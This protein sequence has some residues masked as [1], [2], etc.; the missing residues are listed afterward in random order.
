LQENGY[1]ELAGDGSARQR[2]TTPKTTTY[3][4][5]LTIGWSICGARCAWSFRL[6]ARAN[7]VDWQESGRPIWFLCV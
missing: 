7:S 2:R 5:N 6:R 3:A 1:G 4:H